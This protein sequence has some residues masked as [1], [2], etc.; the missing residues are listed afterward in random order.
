[1]TQHLNAQV[2]VAASES[3][4]YDFVTAV[5]V[6][7]TFHYTTVQL[8]EVAPEDRN[9]RSSLDDV[10]RSAAKYSGTGTVLLVHLNRRGLMPL[11]DLDLGEAPF[12]E[13]WFLWC[14]SPDHQEWCLWAQSLSTVGP[15]RFQY[16]S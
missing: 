7:E 13:V 5:N 10:R 3:A 2:V 12:S 16:P 4:D 15:V 11:A 14:A 9:S 6:D 1:M 8:K